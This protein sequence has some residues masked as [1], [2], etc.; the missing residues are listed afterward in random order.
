M[1]DHKV[2]QRALNALENLI[3]YDF[4]GKPLTDSSVPVAMAIAALREALAHP[5]PEPDAWWL[6]YQT[7]G[8]DVGWRLSPTRSGAGVVN[9]LAG[10]ENERA[11]YLA[12]P[13]EGENE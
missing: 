1:T 2:M 8:G 12:L 6:A 7:L 3:E 5:E 4:H 9:R 13:I 10:Q 11:L